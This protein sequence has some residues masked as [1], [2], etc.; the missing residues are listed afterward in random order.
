VKAF[1]KNFLMGLPLALGAMLSL[2]AVVMAVH[3]GDEGF[4]AIAVG[5]I[6]IPILFAALTAVLKE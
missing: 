1:L 3:G 4:F 6:G 5:L 2:S